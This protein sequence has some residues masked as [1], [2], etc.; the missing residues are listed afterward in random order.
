MPRLDTVRGG[1]MSEGSIW[2]EPL[3]TLI[4][5]MGCDLVLC[6]PTLVPALA[7][8]MEGLSNDGRFAG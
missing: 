3:I 1:R 2:S 8:M 7:G 4:L 5:M 6:L